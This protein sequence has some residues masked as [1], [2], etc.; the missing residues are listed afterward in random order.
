MT[1]DEMKLEIIRLAM[2]A[3]IELVNAACEV[4]KGRAVVVQ[5]APE[6]SIEKRVARR[7]KTARKQS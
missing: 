5:D 6:G 1:N 7:A 2:S 4:L 3:P